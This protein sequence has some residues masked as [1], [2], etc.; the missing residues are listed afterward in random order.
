MRAGHD[1]YQR[2]RNCRW[3]TRRRPIILAAMRRILRCALA[4]LLSLALIASGATLGIASHMAAHEH[5]VE[6]VHADGRHTLSGV[7]HPDHAAHH[8]GMTMPHETPQPSGDHPPKSCSTA[9]TV[10]SPLPA[11]VDTS[12]EFTVSAAVYTNLAGVD[13][14]LSVPVDPGISKRNR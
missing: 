7:E 14:F 12:V 6:H 9:C 11:I 13:G 4:G 2:A 1:G 3:W 8:G 10:A 5:G